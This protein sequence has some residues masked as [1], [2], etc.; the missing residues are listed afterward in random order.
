[1]SS[2]IK[3]VEKRVKDDPR[4]VV[5]AYNNMIEIVNV[6]YSQKVLYGKFQMSRDQIIDV[7][8]TLVRVYEEQTRERK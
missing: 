8:S 6:W 1:M 3:D 7:C 5:Q 4:P 2:I